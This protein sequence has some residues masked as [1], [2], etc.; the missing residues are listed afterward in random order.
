MA[1]VRSPHP[2]CKMGVRGPGLQPGPGG[3]GCGGMLNV[4]MAGVIPVAAA[5]A[6]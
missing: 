1:H 2:G 4:A 5:S 3:A 6:S